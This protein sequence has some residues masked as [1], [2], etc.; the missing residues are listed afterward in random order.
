M[1]G[2]PLRLLS[3]TR[4]CQQ[5]SFTYTI[6]FISRIAAYGVVWNAKCY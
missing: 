3:V 5:L 6:L 4:L 2:Q 1:T